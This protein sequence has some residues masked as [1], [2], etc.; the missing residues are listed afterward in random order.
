[1]KSDY[2]KFIK[3]WQDEFEKFGIK[4]QSKIFGKALLFGD[5]TEWKGQTGPEPGEECHW[6]NAVAGEIS[7][8]SF[9]RIAV[10]GNR[11]TFIAFSEAKENKAK[12]IVWYFGGWGDRAGPCWIQEGVHH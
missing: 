7:E 12:K 4:Q 8:A 9:V 11:E 1:M 3:K 5:I 10:A 6:V 2:E